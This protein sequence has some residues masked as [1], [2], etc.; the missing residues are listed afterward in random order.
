MSVGKGSI[1]RAAETKTK[2]AATDKKEMESSTKMD[3][4]AKEVVAKKTSTKKPS[5]KKVTEPNAKKQ[6]KPQTTTTSQQDNHYGL[7]SQLPIYLM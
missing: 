7:G 4:K 6:A 1:K 2:V 3:T 5:T